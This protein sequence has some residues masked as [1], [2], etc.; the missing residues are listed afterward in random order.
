MRV[1]ISY[2]DACRML[3]LDPNTYS[4]VR[5]LR[6]V[7]EREVQSCGQARLDHRNQGKDVAASRIHMLLPQSIRAITYR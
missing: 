3:V 5:L 6:M 4:C 2:D 1:C 7:G